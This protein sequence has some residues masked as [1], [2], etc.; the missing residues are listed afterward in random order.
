M[1]THMLIF[2]YKKHFF[3]DLNLK[4]PKFSNMWVAGL[5]QGPKIQN[6]PNLWA[7][8]LAELGSKFSKFVGGWAGPGSKFPKFSKFVGGWA[9]PGSKFSKFVG[10]WVGRAGV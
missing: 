6:Y 1:Y 4:F 7:A 9:G 2:V 5:A 10:G 3:P 8:R